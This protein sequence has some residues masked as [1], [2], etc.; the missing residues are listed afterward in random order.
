M[1][2]YPDIHKKTKDDFHIEPL[3]RREQEIFI[4]LYSNEQSLTFKDI[5]RRTGLEEEMIRMYVSNMIKKG[6]PLIRSAGSLLL[7]SEFKTLQAKENIIK[8]N[9]TLAKEIS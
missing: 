7:D 8:I 6:V 9:E 1:F 2:L 5:S 3:T 4:V